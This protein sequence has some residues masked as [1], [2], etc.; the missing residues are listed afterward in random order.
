MVSVEHS[1]RARLAAITWKTSCDRCGKLLH[2]MQRRWCSNACKTRVAQ[3]SWEDVLPKC[4][5]GKV[6]KRSQRLYC[7]PQHRVTVWAA[8]RNL[9]NYWG[10]AARQEYV[11]SRDAYREEDARSGESIPPELI[12]QGGG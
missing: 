9:N 11:L 1:E 6:L 4:W 5:C 10:S 2:G 8:A 7:K 12:T 3:P